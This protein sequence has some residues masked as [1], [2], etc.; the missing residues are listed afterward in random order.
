MD[1]DFAVPDHAASQLTARL[2]Q[3]LIRA[4]A[5]EW[6]QLN[7]TFFKG[8]MRPAILELSPAHGR[9]GQWKR[10]TRT[11]SLAR[12]LV[13]E[14][15]WGELVEVLKHEMA[16]QYVH[17]V[18]HELDD[19]AHGAAF[20]SLCARLGFDA[21][22]SG[23]PRSQPAQ[24][25]LRVIERVARLLALAE[26]PNQHEAE[27]AMAAA[28]RLMLK[29]NL[30]DCVAQAER[31][32]GFRHLGR[33]TGRVEEHQRVLAVILNTHFF[34]EVIWVPVFRPLE[35][36][37][38]SVLEICG[39]AANLEMAEYVHTFLSH[40]A[41]RLWVEHKRA[42]LVAGNR[43]RRVFLAGVMTGFYEKLKEQAA[44]TRE[45]G[46]VWV[47][48]PNLGGYY[49]RRH[50]HIRHARYYGHRRNEAYA[51]GK[52]AGK[53]IVIHRPVQAA[54]QSQG[55]LLGPAKR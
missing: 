17:E 36:K 15:P 52:T 14:H 20:R 37:N 41:E 7:A 24:G 31:S 6:K 12:S 38:G 33:P 50:P 49:R 22:A 9:L 21:S 46:L 48:D 1:P 11:I 23:L 51:H 13:L 54:A 42:N 43:D 44:Q 5:V 3:T 39:T 19:T 25:E 47:G 34:V 28:Q 18:L 16:H 10:D 53:G 29:Y 30:D 55:R 26:S 27:A 4:L 2:E 45:Q 8:V 32:Y 35:G 40:T